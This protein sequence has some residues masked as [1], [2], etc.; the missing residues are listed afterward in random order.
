MWNTAVANDFVPCGGILLNDEM[1]CL[2]PSI[3]HD[4]FIQEIGERC[5]QILEVGGGDWCSILSNSGKDTKKELIAR[6]P[7]PLG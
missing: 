1:G 5:A 2:A 4:A 6:K 7:K 3:F